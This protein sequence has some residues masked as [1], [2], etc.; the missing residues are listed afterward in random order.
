MPLD[1]TPAG[2]VDFA[3]VDR[4]LE[5]TADV[6][7]MGPGPRHR[8]RR[9]RVRAGVVER[10]GVPLVLDADALNAFAGEPERLVGP[11]RRRRDHHA[12]P[13]RDGAAARQ[14]GRGGAARPPRRTHASSPPRIASTSC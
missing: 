14:H 7:A 4:V 11:R 3:A 2:T 8:I 6:I 9:P 5:F 1:E 12:A 10:A 13:G